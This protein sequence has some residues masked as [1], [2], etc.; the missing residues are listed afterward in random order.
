MNDKPKRADRVEVSSDQ[1]KA[2]LTEIK[3]RVGALETIA[4]ISNRQV[5]EA[6]VREH[7]KTDNR[8][9][10]MRECEEPRTREHLMAKFGFKSAAALDYH[11]FPLREDDLIRIRFDEDGTQTFEWSNLFKR[12][13]KKTLKKILDGS[14]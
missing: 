3:E 12:L 6:Y 11:L 1:L 2:E 10:I 14:D 4:S 13:P 9:Q 7:L 5:V 8:K